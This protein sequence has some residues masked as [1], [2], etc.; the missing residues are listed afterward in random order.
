MDF[1]YFAGIPEQL[2]GRTRF[3]GFEQ[4]SRLD[5]LNAHGI[6]AYWFLS[7]LDVNFTLL[8]LDCRILFF[9]GSG[10]PRLP[11]DGRLL[12]IIN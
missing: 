7:A 4:P 12:N 11:V 10:L 3:K 8:L 9:A 6:F 5:T 2:G 1:S